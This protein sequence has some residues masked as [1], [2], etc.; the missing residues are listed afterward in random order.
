MAPCRAIVRYYRCDTPYRAILF[1]GVEHSP[2]MMRYPPWYLISDRHIC[3]IP[4]FATY[5]AK[6]AR[7]P[8]KTSTKDVCDT[9]TTSI[10][11]YE[12]YRCWA[13]KRRIVR[14]A[15]LRSGELKKAVAVSEEKIQQRSRRRGRFSSSHCP[16][17]KMPKPW[18]G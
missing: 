2:K 1:K 12:K 6:I 4:H 18:Q 16:C 10:A 15:C 13:S 5:R 3:A 7:Y 11:R 8:I 14:L 17:R 9:I